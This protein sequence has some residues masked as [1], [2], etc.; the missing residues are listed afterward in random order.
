MQASPKPTPSRT[1]LT[2]KSLLSGIPGY[3]P[4]LA[5][6]VRTASESSQDSLMREYSH[7]S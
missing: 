6:M 5:P 2:L 1:S 7:L 3:S 4:S